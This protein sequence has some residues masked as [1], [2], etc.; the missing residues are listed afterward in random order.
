[1]RDSNMPA[2]ELLSQA[3]SL[4]EAGRLQEAIEAYRVVLERSPADAET[5]SLLGLAMAQSGQPS[6]GVEYLERAV[7]AEPDQ[8]GFRLNLALGLLLS[9]SEERADSEAKVALQLAPGNARALEL[10]GDIALRRQDPEGAAAYWRQSIARE[11]TIPLAVKLL[12]HQIRALQFDKAKAALADLV[13]H[14][15]DDPAIHIVNCE[16]Q[17][18]LRDWSQLE[19]V[20]R[21]VTSRFP[22]RRDGWKWLAT[23][24]FE[25]GRHAGAMAAYRRAFELRAPDADE[26]AAYA[27]LCIHALALDEA[28]AALDSAAA[29]DADH[30]GM[31]Q[32]RALLH[33]YHGQLDAAEACC[34][35]CLAREP[36]N[37]PA[38]TTLTRA[39]R[40]RLEDEDLMV[41][42]RVVDDRAAPF[43]SRIAAGFS[44]GHVYDAR[45]EVGKAMAAYGKA[46]AL[47]EERD[48][49]EG[50]PY[51]RTASEARMALLAAQLEVEPLP[52][53]APGS[54]R[55]VFIVGMPR[56]GTTLAEC[57]IGAHP[58]VVACGE[59]MEMRRVLHAWLALQAEGRT[60]DAATL[61]AWREA[62]LASL[63]DAAGAAYF[64]DKHP[65]NF[66]A[67][68]LIARMFPDAAIVWMRRDPVETCL[69]VYR[70]EFDKRW[71]FVHRLGDIGHY[72]GLHERVMS[73]WMTR[74]PGRIFE[75]RYESFAAD[76]ARQ[77][78]ALV[79]AVGLA[80]DPRCL[81]F[82]ASGR[83]IMTFSTVEARE[84]VFV[85][86]GRAA[87]YRRHLDELLS[88]LAA[89]GVAAGREP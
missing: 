58:G 16:L 19:Q 37:V 81:E 51:D 61:I 46:H 8:A 7:T 6:G 69:S 22:G 2:A 32:R 36:G 48:R 59:R 20:A 84:P 30:A 33:L 44:A 52:E 28:A 24:W 77:A 83:P 71:Q 41:L 63:P 88:A 29:L 39:R 35:R 66:E 23:A 38:Y 68:G 60:P 42:L 73:Q 65:L 70:Q 87:R 11:F 40:G 54:P 75:V 57:V 62:V 82:Q 64:T 15:V 47:A 3:V 12:R 67:V 31:L 49:A 13:P 50:S 25:T 89:A 14:F 85:R 5:A 1:M 76:I 21:F 45:D 4:H 80:W 27:G 26:L 72:Y 17:A 18:A 34:R 9:G 10:L 74:L 43:D 55:P 78:R 53:Q 56:S 79:E 86:S